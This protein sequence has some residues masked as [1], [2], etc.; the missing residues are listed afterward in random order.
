MPRTVLVTGAADGF[1]LKIATWF[2]E[3]GDRV[4]LL[5]VRAD[6][7]E[8]SVQ[9][10]SQAGHKVIGCATDVS[11]EDQVESAVGAT[12]ERWGPVDVV[13]SNAGIA[14][15]AAVLEMPAS[16]WTRTLEVNLTGTFLVTR[17]AARSMVAT[18]TAGR[19]CCVASGAYRL[20]R[21][22]AA[23]YCASK[24][25]LVMYAK[26]L[27][28]ELGPHDITVNVVAPGFIDHG[29]REGLGQF[30]PDEYAAAMRD[31]TPLRRP[32]TPGDIADAVGFLCSASAAH[33]SGAVLPVDGASS[34][35]R[36]TIPWSGA[37]TAHGDL[38]S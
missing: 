8:R 18:G 21:L 11:N 29:H 5:D 30:V 2:A 26:V 20:G 10:L 36:Y 23:H 22:G 12:T 19:I 16:E 9:T 32:G 27:A 38:E 35:G 15:S 34:A 1:G 6:R 3:Q 4:A 7:L 17:A 25:G 33:I 14:P 28:M 37:L 24:A 13:V 31:A